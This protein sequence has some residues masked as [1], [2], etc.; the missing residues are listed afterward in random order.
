MLQGGTVS[1]TQITTEDNKICYIAA[2]PNQYNGFVLANQLQVN[3]GGP[4]NIATIDNQ[5]RF[6]TVNKPNSVQY[7][8][9][10]CGLMFSHLAEVTAHK[11]SHIQTTE[12]GPDGQTHQVIT[13]DPHNI[14]QGQNIINE[15]GQSLA[16]IQILTTESLEPASGMTQMQTSN[17]S[18]EVT[19][20]TSKT[21]MEK[22]KC[23]SCGLH[24]LIAGKRKK[25]FKCNNCIN[26]EN[27]EVVEHHQSTAAPSQI[28]ISPEGDVKFE[29]NELPSGS[30]S[31]MDSMSQT[32]VL[33]PH[34]IESTDQNSMAKKNCLH[35]HHPVKK[36]NQSHVTKCQKC[37]GTGIIYIGN[38]KACTEE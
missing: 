18:N 11:R 13:V 9:D 10:I 36:R 35:G 22:A 1:L 15:N 38:N 26:A 34:D 28:Y 14:L 37:N 2:Q 30:D 7:K 6:V 17:S 3:N 12:I 5:G 16:Q 31:S 23:I 20:T 29:L 8:C 21:N 25:N 33:H 4:V 19:V 24:M 32:V 27:Q